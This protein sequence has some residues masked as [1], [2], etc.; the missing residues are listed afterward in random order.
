MYELVYTKKGDLKNFSK[1]EKYI[2]AGILL[3][4]PLTLLIF[5]SE[6]YKTLI[7]GYHARD[8]TMIER[9]LTQF[10]VLLFYISLILLPLPGR[11]SICHDIV[12]S[13]S[14]FNPITT[15]FSL[16]FL[17][18]LVLL[19]ILRIKKTPY[20]SFA[21]L[22]FFITISVE[23]S[24]LPLEM[25]YEHRIYLSC[26]FLIGALVDFIINRFYDKNKTLVKVLFLLVIISFSIMTTVRSKVWENE[27]TLWGDVNRKYP[28]Y[29]RGYLNL[30]VAYTNS[31]MDKEAEPNYLTAIKLMSNKPM[32]LSTAYNNLGNI[33]KRSGDT[34]LAEKYMLKVLDIRKDLH[35]PYLN[36]A[37]IYFQLGDY[38]KAVNM[39]KTAIRLGP[40]NLTTYRV[41]GLS[42]YYLKDY[43]NALKYL[44]KAADINR[45]IFIL[46]ND[47]GL[48]YM[49]KK[50]YPKAL[51]HFKKAYS[52]NPED[53]LVRKNLMEAE[54]LVKPGRPD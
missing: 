2:A 47:I 28:N 14:L 17:I 25:V 22:W 20:L 40:P 13:T 34:A 31:R 42:Y 27:I 35:Q 6:L 46:Y 36:L 33:Y 52:L 4:L 21:I 49:D 12:K 53:S 26:V 18:G 24:I 30:A 38:M 11:L 48:V 9:L 51:F 37:E 45:E 32:L 1:K 3:V 44:E 50:D 54:K 10:R 19:A 7:F 41:A 15:L 16:I 39:S 5:K 29:G 43:D 23:S 8:F